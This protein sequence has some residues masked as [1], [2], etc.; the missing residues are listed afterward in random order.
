LSA[1]RRAP[2]LIVTGPPGV[3]KTTTA[4]IL[5][6]RSTRAVHLES[7]VFFNFIRAGYVEPWRPA[8]HGQ[9]EVVTGIAAEAAIGYAEAGYLTIVDGI[10]IPGWF[11]EPLRDGLR[12]AGH[13]VA[14]AVLRAP[15]ATCTARARERS[16]TPLGDPRVVER[17]WR[18]FADLGDFE[19]NALDLDGES[20]EEAADLLT[21][22][23]A[24]GVLTI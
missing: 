4:A 1:S 17:L 16:H 12:D 9:N 15:L 10:F 7:D 8:A 5:A 11:L 6:E 2:V 13:G 22:R 19:P 20:P 23:L 14:Y 3:G 24:D 21:R 18:H